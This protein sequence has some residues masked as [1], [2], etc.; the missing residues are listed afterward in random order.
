[1]ST[2]A[3]PSRNCARPTSSNQL[4]GAS[5]VCITRWEPSGWGT[6]EDLGEPVTNRAPLTKS[7]P[8]T[9]T[10]PSNLPA[11]GV[12]PPLVGQETP[13]TPIPPVVLLPPQTP[14]TAP[15]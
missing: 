6:T 1:M 13:T 9:C 7:L 8:L 5:T 12:M 14:A 11:H 4:S 3:V 10:L 15:H 2:R